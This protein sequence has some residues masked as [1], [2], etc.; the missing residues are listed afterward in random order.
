MIGDLQMMARGFPNIRI[1][2]GIVIGE[3]IRLD[4]ELQGERLLFGVEI[5]VDLSC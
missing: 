4:P 3:P 5:Q 2:H 1:K